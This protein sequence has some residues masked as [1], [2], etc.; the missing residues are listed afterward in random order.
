MTPS[1]MRIH[2]HAC[3]PSRPCTE[4][5]YHALALTAA[6]GALLSRRLHTQERMCR[7]FL[8]TLRIG[9]LQLHTEGGRGLPRL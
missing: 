8:D 1:S 2:A 6:S 7:S 3:V 4:S 5:V 9:T